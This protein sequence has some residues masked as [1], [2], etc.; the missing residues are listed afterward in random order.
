MRVSHKISI[1]CGREDCW[2]EAALSHARCTMLE[3]ARCDHLRSVGSVTALKAEYRMYQGRGL[4]VQQD[5]TVCSAVIMPG[6]QQ[7]TEP[8]VLKETI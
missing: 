1:R 5:V 7:K 3:P 4:K 8:T 6:H 2:I